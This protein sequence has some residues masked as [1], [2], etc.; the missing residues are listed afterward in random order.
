MAAAS[1]KRRKPAGALPPR[2]AAAALRVLVLY[3][4]P[5]LAEGR[6]G[7]TAEAGVLDEV[8]AVAVALRARLR[9]ET[10]AARQPVGPLLER[11]ARRDVDVVF[12]LCEGLDGDPALEPA[13]TGLIEL[14][15]LPY[16]GAPPAALALCLDKAR[17]KLLLRGAG[18][19]TPDFAVVGR[20]GSWSGERPA[21][22]LFVKPAAEDASIGIGAHSVCRNARELERALERT[23]RATRGPVLV[24]TYIDG[25]EVNVAVVGDGEVL[26][27]SEMVFTRA[28]G[29][30]PFVSYEAKWDPE[31]PDF[32]DSVPRCPADLPAPVAERLRELARLAFDRTGC[33]DYARVDVRLDGDLRPWVLEVNPNPDI[34]PDAGLAR[35]VRA[36]GRTYEGFLE[37]LARRAAARGAGLRAVA[38]AS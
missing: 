7:R 38:C 2:D 24:E 3:N 1:T 36:S 14:A 11:L 13:V 26:P 34:A 29:G 4:E 33:R 21:F 27:L 35:S 15:G 37:E 25:R 31:H 17:T 10:L 5:G 8:E 23:L 18:V 12:N 22:P 19:P 16:T 32:T 6:D 30:V 9:V 20:D 28:R